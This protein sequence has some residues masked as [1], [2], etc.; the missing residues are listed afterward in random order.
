MEWCET[1]TATGNARLFDR[2]AARRNGNVGLHLQLG[3]RRVVA[4]YGVM[5]QAHHALIGV[6][7]FQLN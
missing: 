3:L 2:L 7:V 5:I 6:P 4:L 1:E